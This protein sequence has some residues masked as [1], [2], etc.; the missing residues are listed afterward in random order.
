MDYLWTPWRYQYVTGSAAPGECVFCTVA[1]GSDD[2]ASLVVHRA[3]HN[4]VI[5]NRYP[6]TN[7]H[8]MV[9]PVEHVAT[10]DAL[11]GE[12]LCEMILL[13]RDVERHLRALYRPDGINM[14]LNI[15]RAAGA[16][17][18]EHV[19]M[20]ALPRWVGD[21]NFMTATAETRV[22]PEALETTWEKLRAAFAG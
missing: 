2:R 7:G 5:L 1:R 19:H 16:G 11:N 22:L 12:T 4:F 8:V 17:I 18:A 3:R 9:V 10:L 20:H 14:G 13:A 6:Y 15:G 21:T